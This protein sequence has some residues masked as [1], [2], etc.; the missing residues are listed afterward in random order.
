MSHP[1]TIENHLAE[2]AE[3]MARPAIYH[4]ALIA[5]LAAQ[6]ARSADHKNCPRLDNL[7]RVIA[8]TTRRLAV[9]DLIQ[10]HD[11]QTIAHRASDAGDGYCREHSAELVKLLTAELAARS[12]DQAAHLAGVSKSAL[13]ALASW[14]RPG[15]TPT[16][17]EQ[18]E[19]L[20]EQAKRA[21]D[22]AR[23]V[24]LLATQA[25]RGF[26]IT[27]DRTNLMAAHA[28]VTEVSFTAPA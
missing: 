12:K 3:R 21:A 24:V 22:D 28:R 15:S 17:L 27:P 13:A 9:L 2:L 4:A 10:D 8:A 19:Q 26:E 23:A 18:S 6:V 20:Q 16:D 11:G 14:F 25:I 1:P 7:E 5:D